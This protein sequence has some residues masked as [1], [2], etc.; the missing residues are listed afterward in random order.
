MKQQLLLLISSLFFISCSNQKEVVVA[1]WEETGNKQ[2]TYN[3]KIGTIQT[4]LDYEYKMYYPDG[5]AIYKKGFFI[6]GKEEGEWNF[7]YKSGKPRSTGSFKEG[8]VNGSFAAYY[9]SGE[10]EQ[11]GEYENGKL[12]KI[13]FYTKN[14]SLKPER[15]DLT[16]L[17]LEASNEWTPAERTEMIDDCSTIMEV[18]Y[19]NGA[20][21]CECMI[22]T[23]SKHVNYSEFEELT[24]HQKAIIFGYFISSNKSCS[25]ILITR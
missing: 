9:E 6:N 4:P 8:K 2:V 22:E 23:V 12:S 19:Q 15:E 7:Y 25:G 13:E 5:K 16:E 1:T 24:E 17:I 11:K 21:F 10:V 14:G 20:K 18:T 3:I